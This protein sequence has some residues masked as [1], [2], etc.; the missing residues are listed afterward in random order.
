M[1]DSIRFQ[2]EPDVM[3]VRQF[4]D[5]FKVDAKDYG[6]DGE[7]ETIDA[8]MCQIDLERFFKEHPEFEFYY[9]NGEWWEGKL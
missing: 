8:C 7:Q 9:E 6:W 5:R 4:Q 1:C 2:K 3:S